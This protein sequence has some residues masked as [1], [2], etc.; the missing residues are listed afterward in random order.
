MKKCPYCAESIQSAAI[1]CRYCGKDLEI[2]KAAPSRPQKGTHVSTGTMWFVGIL[3]VF[4]IAFFLEGN[5]LF[6]E[7]YVP[8]ER[9]SVVGDAY[10]VC[11]AFQNTGL[12]TE[13]DVNGSD[14]FIDVRIDTSG[15]EAR[16]ICSQIIPMVSKHTRKFSGRWKLRIFS[17]YSGSRPIT[18]CVLR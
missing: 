3:V 7:D 18:M 8:K 14:E 13:C 5:G 11:E 4:A 15:A 1:L 17:P 16:K 2:G 9:S 10:R 12:V 6:L